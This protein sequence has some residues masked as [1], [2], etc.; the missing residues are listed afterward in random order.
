MLV[1][2]DID[3]LAL[4]ELQQKYF[5]L[6]Y[7]FEEVV[8]GKVTPNFVLI[9]DFLKLHSNGG[10][11]QAT[12]PQVK[13][14][15]ALMKGKPLSAAAGVALIAK[16]SADEKHTGPGNLMSVNICN[17]RK[18]LARVGIEIETIHSVGYIMRKPHI[19]KLKAL[20]S[21]FEETRT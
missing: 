19:D 20:I 18:I 2:T 17:L 7:K 9:K 11:H 10:Y 3:H 15:A 4:P 21:E 6:V 1:D 5:D 14:V 13:I 8:A 16:S 12:T